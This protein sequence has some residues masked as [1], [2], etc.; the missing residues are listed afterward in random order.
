MIKLSKN[1]CVL[2]ILLQSYDINVN[3]I[4]LSDDGNG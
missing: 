1:L 2:I 4:K 3:V